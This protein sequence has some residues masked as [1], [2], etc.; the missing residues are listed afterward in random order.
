MFY[1]QVTEVRLIK[2]IMT[3]AQTTVEAQVGSPNGHEKDRPVL[4]RLTHTKEKHGTPA[5]SNPLMT[6]LR[7]SL[8]AMQNPSTDIMLFDAPRSSMS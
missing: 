3:K 6:S 1:S 2:R 4:E 5:K 7:M 8:M